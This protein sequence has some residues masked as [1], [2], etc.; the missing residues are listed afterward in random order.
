MTAPSVAKN[1]GLGGIGGPEE[2]LR[3]LTLDGVVV[4]AS[5]A[6]SELAGTVRLL[7]R[8][9]GW[10]VVEADTPDQASWAAGARKTSLVVIAGTDPGFVLKT[11]AAVRRSTA[12]SLAVFAQLSGCVDTVLSVPVPTI[13][14]LGGGSVRCMLAEVFR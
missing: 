7:C 10:S 6:P 1:R 4:L 2:L 12:S 5:D 13:E 14:R 8:D 3:H 9:K 11:V